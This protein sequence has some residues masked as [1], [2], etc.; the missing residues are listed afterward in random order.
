MGKKKSVGPDGIPGKILKFGGEAMITY[1]ARLLDITMTNNA[2]PG[3]WKKAIVVPMYKGRDR[4]VVGN[5]RPAGQINLGGLKKS[6][7]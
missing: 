6:T 7:L 4:S 2:I 1:L 5:Y 3:E